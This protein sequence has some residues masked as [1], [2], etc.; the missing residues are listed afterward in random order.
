MISTSALKL[1]FQKKI[2]ITF[3]KNRIYRNIIN[4]NMEIITCRRQNCTT[5]GWSTNGCLTA[6][7]PHRSIA[8]LVSHS[9]STASGFGSPP[10]FYASTFPRKK[11]MREREKKDIVKDTHRW[12]SVTLDRWI[13]IYHI[14][15][16]NIF[17]WLGEQY[18]RLI[19]YS[20]KISKT[21]TVEIIH[22]TFYSWKLMESIYYQSGK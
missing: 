15:I 10:C 22:W 14:Y 1:L 20:F 7:L 6:P 9:R 12:G 2:W 19:N 17:K 13:C 16:R 11:R 5:K 4:I 3:C 21:E 8:N 18:I